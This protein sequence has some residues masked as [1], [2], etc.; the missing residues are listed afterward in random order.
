[1]GEASLNLWI[2]EWAPVAH[3]VECLLRVRE[4]VGSNPV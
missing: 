2:H 4:V 3:L 1:M